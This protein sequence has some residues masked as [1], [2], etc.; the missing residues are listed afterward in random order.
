MAD[1][2]ATW[3]QWSMGVMLTVIAALCGLALEQSRSAYADIR[4]KY[5]RQQASIQD[6]RERVIRLEQWITYQQ[7]QQQLDRIETGVNDLKRRPSR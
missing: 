6:N 1:Q 4:E 3:R 2:N 7:Q 5:D